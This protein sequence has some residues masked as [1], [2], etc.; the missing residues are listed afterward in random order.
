MRLRL[1]VFLGLAL[2]LGWP[3][4]SASTFG[5]EGLKRNGETSAASAADVGLPPTAR[6]IEQFNYRDLDLDKLDIFAEELGGEPT[7]QGYLLAVTGRRNLVEAQEQL[8]V[9][10]GY[11]IDER[12]V[13][14][15][16]L[17]TVDG[18]S[19]RTDMIE[20]WVVPSGALPP[21]P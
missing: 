3:A 7:A 5:D 15:Y 11:L 4:E 6:L 13:G 10:K 17:V 20:L 1:W 16:R 21:A 18:G 19:R 9:A 12:G 8:D 2:L 14:A